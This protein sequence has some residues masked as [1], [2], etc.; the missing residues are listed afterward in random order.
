MIEDGALNPK[1]DY[2]TIF[3]EILNTEGH[4]NRITGSKVTAILL[5]GW[6]LP[7]GGV[8]SGRVCAQ[9]AKQACYQQDRYGHYFV[10][11]TFV[12]DLGCNRVGGGCV[13]IHM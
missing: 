1:I 11:V 2:V 8:A 7:V 13:D 3:L 10:Y 5:N 6:I 12:L 4:P 9:P